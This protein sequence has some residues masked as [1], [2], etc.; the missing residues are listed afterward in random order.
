MGVE[1]TR[2]RPIEGAKVP[3]YKWTRHFLVEKS[4]PAGSGEW[5]VE[6]GVYFFETCTC[7]KGNNNKNVAGLS[8]ISW[9]TPLANECEDCLSKWERPGR[10]LYGA[11]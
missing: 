8:N 10:G 4:A 3:V 9:M 1:L 5:I 6:G 11:S 2:Y 7:S